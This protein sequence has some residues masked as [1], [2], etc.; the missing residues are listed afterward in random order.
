MADVV[1]YSRLVEQDEAGTL[2]ALKNLRYDI[3]DPLLSDHRGRMIKLLGDGFL[4]EFASV[5][6]AVNC[7][8]A[9]QKQAAAG[10]AEIAPERRIVLRI[11][12][13]LGDVVVEDHD[14]LGDGVNIAARLEQLC[15]PGGVLISGTAY[16]HLQGRFGLPLD[17][18]GEQQVKNIARPVRAYRVDFDGT[19]Q[20][21][22]MRFRPYSRRL[23][24]AAALAAIVLVAGASWSAFMRSG[25]APGSTSNRPSVAVLSFDDMSGNSAPTYYGDGVAEDIISMLSRVP[26]LKVVARNSSF[27]YKGRPV[28]VRQ[29]GKE[30]GVTHVL[31]GSIRKDAD[32]L[33]IV[34]QLIDAKTGEHVWAERFD[35]SGTDPWAL[36]D[37]VTEK[38]VADLVGDIGTLKKAQYRDAWGKDSTSLQEYD[39]YLRAHDLL[40]RLQLEPTEQARQVSIEGL[41]KFPGSAL[42]KLELGYAYFVRGWNGWSQDPTADYRQAGA[43]VRE[44]LAQP[45][46]SPMERRLGHFLSAFILSTERKFELALG[47]AEAAIDLSP[48][49]VYMLAALSQIS[50][51]AG[52]TEQALEWIDRAASLDANPEISQELAVY[53]GWTLAVSGKYEESL[54]AFSGDHDTESTFGPVM[55]AIVLNRLGRTEAAAAEL[56][57]AL[58]IDPKFTQAKW[59]ELSFYSDPTIVE[60]EIADLASL[61]LPEK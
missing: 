24:W 51:M 55:R 5:V 42:L 36:Q 7:A 58:Q 32:R 6:D 4:A 2:S 50:V 25:A 31:E 54:A 13:N 49:D 59:R 38:I 41:S 35:R 10:Q 39:Y 53:R 28:D 3:L 16:D 33:R 18:A 1:G 12:I 37:E 47:E 46:P 21:W 17:Y 11:G 48:H 8:V 45:A 20:P 30:L 44:A 57:K 52:N 22:R 29:V 23:R 9:V 40:T 34:A 14:L 15:E 61:G 27:T 60:H 26:D 56:G 43:L 19:R